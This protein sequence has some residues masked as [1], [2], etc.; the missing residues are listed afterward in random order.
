MMLLYHAQVHSV[1][2]GMIVLAKNG[3]ILS[4]KGGLWKLQQKKKIQR[5]SRN[6]DTGEHGKHLIRGEPRVFFVF[7]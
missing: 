3:S 2:A 7:S 5:E 4:G 1:S 6:I